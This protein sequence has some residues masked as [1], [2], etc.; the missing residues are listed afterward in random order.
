MV[1]D[2]GYQGERG[3]TASEADYRKVFDAISDAI[4]IYDQE[5]D[6][7]LDVNQKLCE[8]FGYTAEE[9]CRLKVPDLGG[10]E[11]QVTPQMVRRLM[12]GAAGEDPQL[13]PWQVKDSAGMPFWVEVHLRPALIGG[14][15]RIVMVLRDVTGRQLTQQALKE[16]EDRF[17]TVTE[18]SLA[19]VYIIQDDKFRYVNPVMAQIFGYR[20]EELVDRM[21]PLDLGHPEEHTYI[22]DTIRL[23]LARQEEAGRRNYRCLRKDGRA[24][25]VQVWSRHIDYQGRPA[26]M[27]TLLDITAQRQAEE[28]LRFSE[29]KYRLVTE[30]SLAGVYIIA[31]GK[32]HYVNPRL[33][34]IFG[35]RVEEVINRLGPEDLTHPEDRPRVAE[36]LRQRWQGE[37]VQEFTFRGLR[38][39]GSVIRCKVL[40]RRVEYHG[41]PALIGTLLDITAQQRSEEALRQS[42][43]RYRG[44]VEMQTEMVCRHLPDGTVTFVNEALCRAFGRPREELLGRSFWVSIPEEEQSRLQE[45]LAGL[46]RDNPMV[47]L[48]Q[49]VLKD[50]GEVS[51]QQWTNQAVF[52]HQGRI[53]EHQAVGRDITAR[54]QAE[55]AL[56]QS[57]E[58]YRAIV[59]DQTEL[60]TRYLPDGTVTFVNEANCR[61]FSKTREEYLG[62]S[63]MPLIPQEDRVP[64]QQ[65]I[66]AL[67][68]ENPIV[69]V[70]H[71]VKAPGGHIRWQ[72]WT[73][74]AIFDD[75]GQLKEYQAVGRDITSRRQAEEALL[76]ITNTLQTLIQA[77]PLAII[78]LDRNCRLKIWNP[79]AT[80]FFGWSEAEMLGRSFTRVVPKKYH[81]EF[82][83]MVAEEFRGITHT[84][85]ELRRHR[86]DGSFIYVS[87][88]TAPLRNARGEITLT[89]GIMA[90]ITARKQAEEALK[91]SEENYRTIFNAVND[92]IA[93][94]DLEEI[95]FLD[96]NQ[97]WSQMSGFSAEEAKHLD[98]AALCLQ[99]SP[100]KVE[101]AKTLIKKAVAEGEPQ[102]FEW[103]ARN[104]EGRPHWVE[105]NLKRTAIGGVDRILAVVRDIGERKRVEEALK[106]SEEKLRVLTSQLLTAQESERRRV[107]RELHDE[108]GQALTVLKMHM[109][110][111]ADKLTIK[112]R[113]LKEECEHL[114]T[115]TNEI[116]ENVRRLSWDLSPS[117]LEDLGLSSSL[118]HLIEEVSDNHR[119]SCSIEIDEIN[120]LFAPG[121]QINIY[122]IFQES[123]N[124]IGKHARATKITVA[125]QRRGDRVSF[126]VADN[127]KGFDLRQTASRNLLEKRLGLT[128]MNERVRMAGGNLE[129][130]SKKD[131]G[132]KVSF[133][134]PIDHEATPNV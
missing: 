13:F 52:D 16:S 114:L 48:E 82:K 1:S 97:K 92:A 25:V 95:R 62:Q 61:Y 106:E 134:I 98:L 63:F 103:L 122:R 71:R 66:A 132:T 124:N 20:P 73:N 89:M 53:L 55:E 90:D 5:S 38:R 109:V 96:V 28:A 85:Q 65:A 70:E 54:R 30:D 83:T 43:E 2:Q 76:E 37:P 88:W 115:H 116:I 69:T 14:R 125:A 130:W 26:V 3:F 119:L 91:A 50:D 24:I 11:F 100:F 4:L 35:Y 107:A 126:T 33:A 18:S 128:A 51:W 15:D 110:A 42:E 133:T 44:I 104:R 41:R 129:V 56:R 6:A 47:V 58:R 10:G 80:R 49:Q 117:S 72:Q 59:E 67:N 12:T 105:V 87:L 45:K 111:V 118:R 121:T 84:I 127:G 40:S 34:E 57:E 36:N 93:V 131:Q 81:Q 101:Y 123:L 31:E 86:Q 22:T 120:H 78:A 39:D 23:R 113:A 32:L 74:R 79:A 19:G 68:R 102:I 17:R 60:V 112:Q 21:G 64:L 99:E 9:A 94:V 8:M 108:L 46:S 75:R 77:S 29:E 7:I 27:G